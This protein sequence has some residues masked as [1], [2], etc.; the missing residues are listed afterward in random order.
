MGKPNRRT[1]QRS[2]GFA[3]WGEKVDGVTSPGSTE[4][5]RVDM[6]CVRYKSDSKNRFRYGN[7]RGDHETYYKC[8]PNFIFAEWLV[9]SYNLLTHTLYGRAPRRRRRL[10]R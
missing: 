5:Q 7:E 10:R 8:Y 1:P 3:V 6:L 2:V 9:F 4:Y